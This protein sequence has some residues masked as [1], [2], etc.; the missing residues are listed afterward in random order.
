MDL[1]KRE[2][3]RPHVCH[4]ARFYV[5]VLSRFERVFWW[6]NII[7][8]KRRREVEGAPEDAT[9][10]FWSQSGSANIFEWL[11]FR[12][13]A[14]KGNWWRTVMLSVI[15]YFFKSDVWLL[16]FSFIVFP[17]SFFST[18]LFLFFEDLS[19]RLLYV[20]LSYQSFDP[21]TSSFQE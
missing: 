3:K 8:A 10:V 21:S 4:R 15:L 13:F 6:K 11:Q 5:H 19:A 12:R 20:G 17:D 9:E 7:S 16:V 2:K 18:I 1:S 14:C